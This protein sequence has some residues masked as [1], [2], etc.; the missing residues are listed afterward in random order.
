MVETMVRRILEKQDS[1]KASTE[2]GMRKRP[3]NLEW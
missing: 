1:R 3:I 2:M